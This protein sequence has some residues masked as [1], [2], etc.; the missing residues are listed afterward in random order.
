MK[1]DDFWALVD[2]GRITF[3]A[4]GTGV[5]APK[6]YL[7]E[8]QDG[9]VPRSWWPH[10]EVGHSQ[11]AKREIQALFPN[12]EPFDTPK[13]ERLLQRIIEVSTNVG[14]IVLDCFV[15]SGTTAAVAHKMGRRWV[16][17]ERKAET[18]RDFVIPRLKKVVAGEDPGGITARTVYLS[19]ELPENVKPGEASIA[20]KTLRAL[21]EAER[22]DVPGLSEST[23]RA[24]L[25]HLRAF[26][27]TETEIDWQGG[28]GF[29]VLE[30]APSMFVAQDGVVFLADWATNGALAEATA[31]QLGYE[32]A[33]APPF[34]GRKGR[35]RLAVVDG[36]VDEGATRLL[37]SALADDELLQVCATAIDP[38][39]PKLL[40]SL[41]PG[42]TARKIPASILTA[43][44][45]NVTLWD[46]PAREQEAADVAAE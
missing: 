12:I 36:L 26:D 43:Y 4:D 15:G 37:V 16:A 22:L 27:R 11:E 21:D 38:E 6:L 14:D 10:V 5:P 17:I 44:R 28:G 42:S 31:A 13:P 34:S 18:I 25:R 29:R 3:G 9:L 45:T 20:A 2:D 23:V 40:R 33:V 41:R 39:V 19:E 7:N 8:V 32:Y 35:T 24:L 46:M 1:E 30:V